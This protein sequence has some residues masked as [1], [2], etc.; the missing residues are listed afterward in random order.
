MSELFLFE[1]GTCKNGDNLINIWID[2]TQSIFNEKFDINSIESLGANVY[3]DLFDK[4]GDYKDG[5]R[6]AIL[7]NDT[8]LVFSSDFVGSI[9]ENTT[10]IILAFYDL[11]R[12]YTPY[13]NIFIDDTIKQDTDINKYTRI[14][15]HITDT[16]STLDFYFFKKD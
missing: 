3:F 5:D 15:K 7:K 2:L 14:I 16:T 12:I 11:L 6:L 8:V 1:F 10:N 13:Y 9:D 4:L